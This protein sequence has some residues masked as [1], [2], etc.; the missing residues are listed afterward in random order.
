MASI[1]AIAPCNFLVISLKKYLESFKN[2]KK[3]LEKICTSSTSVIH[4]FQAWES[5]VKLFMVFSF[6]F[7]LTSATEKLKKRNRG[8]TKFRSRI[9]VFGKIIHIYSN[10][11]YESWLKSQ[12]SQQSFESYPMYFDFSQWFKAIRKNLGY[13]T[14][15]LK[16]GLVNFSSFCM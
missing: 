2:V 7:P 11:K 10:G 1:K 14:L 16:I 13:A 3:I 12:Y 15:N 4:G 9:C 8:L 6:H 5:S